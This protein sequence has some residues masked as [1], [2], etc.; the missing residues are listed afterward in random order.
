MMA[1]AI[2]AASPQLLMHSL[3][4]WGDSVMVSASPLARSDTS[5]NTL[6]EHAVHCAAL[7]PSTGFPLQEG[8]P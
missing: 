6:W 8:Q 7:H 2:V 4:C 5:Q 3:L 1:R